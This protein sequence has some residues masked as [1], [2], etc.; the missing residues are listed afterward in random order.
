MKTKFCNIGF[1]FAILLGSLF[2]CSQEDTNPDSRYMDLIKGKLDCMNMPRPE[3]SFDYPVYPGMEEWASYPT[4]NLQMAVCQIPS[5]ILDSMSTQAVVQA[6]W[7]HPLFT[8]I[9]K[10]EGNY[11]SGFENIIAKTNAYKELL[12]REDGA[13]CLLKINSISQK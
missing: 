3:D 9:A 11:K 4:L 7:E 8:D 5:S 1:L 10:D 2:S 13:R 6:I 12:M